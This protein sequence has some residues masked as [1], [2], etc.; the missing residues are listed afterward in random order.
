MELQECREMLV[1]E[2][3]EPAQRPQQHGNTTLLRPKR[4]PCK[5]MP[6]ARPS[7]RTLL[8]HCQSRLASTLHLAGSANGIIDLKAG[9]CRQVTMPIPLPPPPPP[10]A[11]RGRDS[12]AAA[13]F[14]TSYTSASSPCC[15]QTHTWTVA[16]NALKNLI[17]T[18]P[19]H[20]QGYV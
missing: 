9:H 16:N 12:E 1:A 11:K 17:V 15:M 18:T 7:G 8:L 4:L 13:P 6:F 5:G 20:I 2:R 3:H 14:A 19:R 10:R